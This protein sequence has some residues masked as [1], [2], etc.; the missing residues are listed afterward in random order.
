MGVLRTSGGRWVNS[1]CFTPVHAVSHDKIQSSVV[2]STVI[3]PE[4]NCECGRPN[5]TT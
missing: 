1:H 5:L 4:Q 3:V 2:F